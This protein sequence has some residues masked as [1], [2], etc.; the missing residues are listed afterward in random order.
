VVKVGCGADFSMILDVQGGL[1]SF[2]LPEH[3][4]LGHNTDGQY[5]T[6]GN[7]LTFNFVSA[8]KKI[9]MFIEKSK[10]GHTVPLQV[11]NFVNGL[12]YHDFRKKLKVEP[13]ISKRFSAKLLWESKK[14]LGLEGCSSGIQGFCESGIFPKIVVVG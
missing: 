1:H 5:F 12:C 10:D 14:K 6:N 2:G 3:G 4:Q 11:R 13:A 9:V 7:K 8:P